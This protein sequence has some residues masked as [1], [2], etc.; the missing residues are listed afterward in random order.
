MSKKIDRQRTKLACNRC[1]ERKRKCDGVKPVCGDC[2]K[3][4]LDDCCMYSYNLDK[5]RPYSKSYVE[6]LI[7]Y[8]EN[9]ETKLVKT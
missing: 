1:R 4:A 3:S 7:N 5:R 8:I 2:L 6:S 9:L